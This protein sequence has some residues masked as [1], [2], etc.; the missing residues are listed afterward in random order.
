[1]T[2]RVEQVARLL[3]R[4]SNSLTGERTLWKEEMVQRVRAPSVT[5]E[6]ISLK[7]KHQAVK[8]E[9]TWK[10]KG[11][12]VERAPTVSLDPRSKKKYVDH[13]NA[14]E[15]RRRQESN[16]F[17]T[18]NSNQVTD[19]GARFEEGKIYMEAMLKE[20]SKDATIATYLRFGPYHEEYADDVYSAVIHKVEWQSNVEVG[21]HK[22]RLHSHIWLTV[23]HYSQL[24]INVK[25]LQYAARA[26]YNKAAGT[27]ELRMR[28]LPYVHVKL[29]PQSDWTQI[30]KS[31][32][33]KGMKVEGV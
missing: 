27:S 12:S 33:H 25:Q 24:Q 5:V 21:P 31:Y 14:D 9:Q 13:R 1:M 28:A 19:T 15:P 6:A 18:I 4:K 7:A 20:L 23:E 2:S 29:L 22:A 30:M 8:K 26:A 17:L 11:G 32:I 16:F 10:Y 3:Y